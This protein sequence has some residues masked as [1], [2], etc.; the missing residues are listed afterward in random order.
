MA[1]ASTSHAEIAIM[2]RGAAFAPPSPAESFE[3][4]ASK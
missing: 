4:Q 1:P 2:Q 3:F